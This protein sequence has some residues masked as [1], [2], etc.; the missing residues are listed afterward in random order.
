MRLGWRGRIARWLLL[1][2]A[3]PAFA[4]P[5]AGDR[6]LF[7]S[8]FQDAQMA[9]G[10]RTALSLSRGAA[11][12]AAA[13]PEIGTLIRQRQTVARALQAAEA[14][15]VRLRAADRPDR[16]TIKAAA[17]RGERARILLAAIDA[18]L[19]ER[20]PA[21]VQ[22][23]SIAP[24]DADSAA[25]LLD[26]QEAL[27]LVYPTAGATYVFA[28]GPGGRGWQRAAISEVEL[29]E[30]VRRL[31][32]GLDPGGP[33]RGGEDAA[34]ARRRVR[35][36]FDRALAHAAYRLLW[37]P[38]ARFI[39]DARTVYVVPGGALGGL[40]L[41]VL[42]GS[43]PRGDDRDPA[44]L[45]RTDWLVRRHALVTLPSIGSLRALRA[46]P[47]RRATKGFAGFGDP[48]LS[49]AGGPIGRLASLPGARPELE[50]LAAIFDGGSTAIVAGDAAT[51]AAVRS[52][53]LSARRVVAFATHGLL[54]G[55]LG[56]GA[57]PALVFTPGS[58]GDSADDG[59]LTAS[60]ASTLSLA[61]DWVILSACNTAADDGAGGGAIGPGA[62]LL[63]SRRAG[64]AGVALARARRHG[65]GVDGR[66][67]GC[68][69]TGSGGGPCSRAARRDVGGDRRCRASRA[70][71]SGTV[72]TIRDRGRRALIAGRG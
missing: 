7:D 44:E 8:A 69:G 46:A 2:V 28:I 67:A 53:D 5:G 52:A 48:V 11:R 18:G 40:P 43:Q 3:G 42:V 39:G 37:A 35:S 70:R 45:R 65:S 21:Y 13:T 23:T 38:V 14:E 59:L 29:A 26:R 66:Y 62:R 55:E 54:A 20:A 71:R 41:S 32:V 56:E 68:R 31:R 10:S 6:P 16:S 17:G 49:G 72:G 58:G 51:E 15:E 34:P 33:A 64:D 1:M 50:R 19:A 63:L 36:A 47:A 24:V 61:A 22:L 57:E 27:L 12:L 30:T 9:I 4:A 25:A 60:E